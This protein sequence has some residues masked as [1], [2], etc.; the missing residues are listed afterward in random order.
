MY[1]TDRYGTD[2][3]A[4]RGS[5]ALCVPRGACG[6]RLY[7]PRAATRCAMGQ[8]LCIPWFLD[9]APARSRPTVTGYTKTVCHRDTLAARLLLLPQLLCYSTGL[10]CKMYTGSRLRLACG[11]S[12]RSSSCCTTALATNC[13]RTPEESTAAPHTCLYAH[14]DAR[15]CASTHTTCTSTHTRASTHIDTHMHVARED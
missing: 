2:V 14:T 13:E 10:L 12:V 7:A 11:C 15:T 6:S 4:R 3:C 8:S 9:L 5:R 1:R